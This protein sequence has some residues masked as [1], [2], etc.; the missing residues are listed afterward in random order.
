[1]ATMR[2]RMN[3]VYSLEQLSGKNTLIHRLHPCSKMI[4]TLV[5]IVCVT[6]QGKYELFA[7][8]PFLF[9]PIIMISLSEIPFSAIIKRTFVAL[10]FTLF[11]GISN[12]IFDRSTYVVI[13]DVIITTGIISFLTLMVKACLCVSAVLIL[14]ATTHF[15]EITQQ[16]AKIHVPYFIISLLEMIYR[17]ICVLA[18]EAATMLVAY[19]LRNPRFQWPQL[20]H[21]GPFIGSLFLRSLERSERIYQAM[22]CRGYGK[23]RRRYSRRAW[24]IKDMLFTAAGCFS[25]ILFVCL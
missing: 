21:I 4:V 5:Y 11:A 12:I 18:E 6:T 16:L 1:M 23:K 14:M 8:A 9:Y 17:Y 25:G 3:E 22:K 20:K 13:G 15:T 7:M 24:N 10:P 2:S 19:R